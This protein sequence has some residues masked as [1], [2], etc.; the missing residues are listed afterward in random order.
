VIIINKNH[1][2]EDILINDDFYMDQNRLDDGSW[3]FEPPKILNLKDKI[4]SK[5]T[6]IKILAQK[7]LIN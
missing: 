4:M 2:K 1:D 5:G 6:K 3:S 7:T